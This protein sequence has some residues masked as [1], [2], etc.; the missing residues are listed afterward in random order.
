VKV[1]SFSY[2]FPHR[3]QPTWGVFVQ[4]RLAALSKRLDLQVAAPVP[5]FPII[6]RLRSS[7]GP[8][9]EQWQG[10][11]VHRPRFFYLPGLLK[12]SDG[13]F[14]AR[15]L[16]N[17]L[18]KL[19]RQWRP[20]LLDAHFAWPDGV[21]VS[22]LARE[23]SLP[24]VITLRGKIYPC[25]EVPS[26]RRQCADALQNAAAVISVS[27]PMA[28][29]ARELGVSKD[30][31][32]VIANGVDTDMF[33][34]TGDKAVLRE[35]LGLGWDGRLIVTL[36]HL[37][38]RK[39]HIE[40]INALARLPDDVKLVLVGADIEGGKNERILRELAQKLN[41]TDRVI[42]TGPQP[43][44]KM[45]LYLN[46][47]DISVLASY[48]E[49]CPNVVLESLACGTPVIATDVGQ[50]PE[51]L[52]VP[53]YGRIIPVRDVDAL[54]KAFTE[55]LNTPFSAEAVARAPSVKSWDKVAEDVHRVFTDIIGTSNV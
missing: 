8:L 2:C 50:V 48:R 31:I 54:V 33:R 20:D 26:Q 47:A 18:D 1:L 44:D 27:T 28:Q 43:Y 24:Y 37:G 49:G 23:L 9:R 6:T 55:V 17:W 34:P 21:G 12:S 32:H 10:L 4:Q 39:G 25:L 41:L 53:D 36:A 51:L 52:P 29:V 45:P 42:L 11:T 16:R 38:P 19:S 7:P 40:V 35:Q 15:G 5:S 30:R 14:Y 22:L 46:A 3:S 13:C